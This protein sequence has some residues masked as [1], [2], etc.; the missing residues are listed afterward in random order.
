MSCSSPL[1]GV[2]APRIRAQIN[3]LNIDSVIHAEIVCRGSCSSSTFDF[4]IGI[5]NSAFDVYAIGLLTAQVS[6]KIY[7]YS[8]GLDVGDPILEGLA[9]SVSVDQVSGTARVLGRDYSSVLIDLTFQ[10]CTA[11][12][13]PVR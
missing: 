2:R 11:I 1:P 4:T 12:K 3:G 7:I 8:R 6:V 9:D 5:T 10:S 13:L